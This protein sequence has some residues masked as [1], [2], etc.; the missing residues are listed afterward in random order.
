MALAKKKYVIKHGKYHAG[1]GVTATVK[2]AGDIV[3]LSSGQANA[4]ADMVT[5]L[6]DIEA[7]KAAEVSVKDAHKTAADAIAQRDVAI[8]ELDEAKAAAART[9][10]SGKKVA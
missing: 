6:A 5:P 8:A 3:E 2:R 1:R 9:S 7:A 10:G 4:F